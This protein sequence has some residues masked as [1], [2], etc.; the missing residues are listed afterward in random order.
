MAR[1]ESS[2]L[3]V[4]VRDLIA[5]N[6]SEPSG[7][8]DGRVPLH[9]A[10]NAEPSRG[11][12]LDKETVDLEKGQSCFRRGDVAVVVR[13]SPSPFRQDHPEEETGLCGIFLNGAVRQMRIGLA[14]WG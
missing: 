3:E 1:S 12:S 5:E 2:D 13:D 14:N 7:E 6:R 4:P 9:L 10:G 8:G 11:S